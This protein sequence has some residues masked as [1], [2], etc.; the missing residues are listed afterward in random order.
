[1]AGIVRGPESGDRRSRRHWSQARA[2]LGPR[3]PRLTATRG[4]LPAVSRASGVSPGQSPRETPAALRATLRL[5]PSVALAARPPRFAR[6]YP[7]RRRAPRAGRGS[8]RRKEDAEC[9]KKEEEKETKQAGGLEKSRGGVG[10]C[11]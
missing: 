11:G 9:I 7:R 3:V 8:A 1:M 4:E 5:A 2:A 6:Q 10:G